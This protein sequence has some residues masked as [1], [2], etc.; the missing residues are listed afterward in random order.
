MFHEVWSTNETPA[1]LNNGADPTL[2][3]LTLPPPPRGTRARFV[4]IPPDTDEFLAHVSRFDT[5]RFLGWT[6]NG[7]QNQVNWTDRP[8]VSAPSI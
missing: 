1:P 8:R 6:L 5:L 4:D 7:T 3:P 2:G